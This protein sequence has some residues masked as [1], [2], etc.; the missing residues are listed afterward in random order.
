MAEHG[1]DFV[2][3]AVDHR[4]WTTTPGAISEAGVAEVERA[5]GWARE[6]RI[7]VDLDLHAA[8]GYYDYTRPRVTTLWQDGPAGDDARRQFTEVW[9]ALARRYKGVPSSELSFD[10]VNE[11]YDGVTPAAYL[12]AAEPV[13]AAIRAEDPSRLI[14]ADGLKWAKTPVP[15]LAGL[16]IAQS[17]H[18]YAPAELTHYKA[19]WIDGSDKWP[20]PTWPLQPA[21]NPY[22]A[23]S[24]HKDFQSPLLLRGEFPAGAEVRITVDTVA[25]GVDLIV[26][27]DGREVLRKQFTPGPGTGEWKTSTPRPQ[28][29]DYQAIYERPY[30]ATLASAATE[31]SFEATTGDWL[32]FSE[33]RVR[34]LASGE[35]VLRPGPGGFGARQST[36]V[37]SANGT[38]AP[39]SGHATDKE[40][41][42][43]S[44][45]VPWTQL[46]A[47]GVGVHVGEFGAHSF[48]PHDVVLRWMADVLELFQ[49]AGFG[50]ALWNLRGSFGPVDS[51]RA[52]VRYEEYK[53]HKLDRAML[54][55]LRHG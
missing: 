50:W 52:D 21:P 33:I 42:W 27:A 38:A 55:L 31:I 43:Q 37:V 2:R 20:V 53:G 25:H 30:A 29:N 7:H 40:D 32:S 4:R 16:G 41:L 36:Y 47:S 13:V 51:E 8:P 46:A 5:M 18:M 9:R 24:S 39:T 23:G 45:I 17:R 10:L 12:R 15:E 26:R 44:E 1:F 54:E 6:R 28:Y 34:P 3:L 48:T 14:I 19:S 22:L 11:P 49:R 35:L